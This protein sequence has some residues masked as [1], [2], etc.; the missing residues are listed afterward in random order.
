ME[1]HCYP[2]SDRFVRETQYFFLKNDNPVYFRTSNTIRQKAVYAKDKRHKLNN[3]VYAVQCSEVCMDLQQGTRCW[4][5]SK[6][7]KSN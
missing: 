5:L 2:L 1:Q 7:E 4:L 3:A 6:T